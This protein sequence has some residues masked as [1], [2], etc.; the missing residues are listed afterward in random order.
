[1]MMQKSGVEEDVVT[2]IRR[3]GDSDLEKRF[4]SENWADI[5]AKYYSEYYNAI[6]CMELERLYQN[7]LKVV[8]GEE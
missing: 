1:M 6:Y 2:N 7:F 8:T 5:D 4:L 3:R